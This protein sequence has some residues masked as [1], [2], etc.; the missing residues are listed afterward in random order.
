M[1]YIASTKRLTQDRI[2]QGIKLGPKDVASTDW[3]RV[4]ER[5]QGKALGPA[6]RDSGQTH[7]Q[8]ARSN[9]GRQ[10]HLA[11]I[12]QATNT[13][14]HETVVNVQNTSRLNVTILAHAS[15]LHLHRY[16]TLGH[17]A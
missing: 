7:S 10:A 11:G 16:Q 8:S 1:E 9:L 15:S 3:A 17:V 12:P 5:K 2:H 14:N 4:I 6:T 13:S